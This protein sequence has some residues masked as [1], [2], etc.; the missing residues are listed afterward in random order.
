[1]GMIRQFA[2]GGVLFCFMTMPVAG[3]ADIGDIFRTMDHGTSA[4]KTLVK[5]LVKATETGLA[6][7][8]SDLS[9]CPKSS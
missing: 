5:S 4:E 1:M 6:E 3:V 2:K 8:N 7:A 9:V